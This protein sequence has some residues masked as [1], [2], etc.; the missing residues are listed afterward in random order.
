M[1]EYERVACMCV[2]QALESGNLKPGARVLVHGGAGGVGHMAVQ[3]AKV[4]WKAH[5]VATTGPATLTFVKEVCSF[6]H[7]I[8][9]DSR[10][11]EALRN[12]GQ[13]SMH[14]PHNVELMCF[15]CQCAGHC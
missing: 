13:R 10:V 1:I 2:A 15:T 9:A 3:L 12:T 14:A 4:H 7:P 6:P 11:R 8:Q 5:V